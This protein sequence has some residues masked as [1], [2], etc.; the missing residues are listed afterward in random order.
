MGARVAPHA[1]PRAGDGLRRDRGERTSATSRRSGTRSD[2]EIE[3]APEVQ[4]A[5]RFNLF[6]LMQATARAEGHGVARQGRHRPR[7]RGPLLLGRAR[8]TSCRSWSTQARPGRSSCS[9]ARYDMLGAAR[10]PGARGRPSRR[11]VS[12][13]HDQR[14]GGLGLVRGGHGAVPHQRRHR[15][16]AAPLQP[17]LR[18]PRLPARPG[19]R[20]AGGDRALLARPRVL[21]RAPRRAVLHPRGHRARTS[22]RPWSTTTPTRTCSRRRTSRSPRA[23][24]SGWK[25]PDPEGARGARTR[26]RSCTAGRGR[27][28][29]GAP[30]S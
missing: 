1:R 30:P 9:A 23:S 2:V 22:T 18:R 13:A 29:G 6:Q 15:L 19:R 14:R 25:A 3:G 28:A 20:G 21:L 12:V 10:T 26:H 8:S 4:R 7:L 17:R 24:S 5:V 11:A 27:R 16:R